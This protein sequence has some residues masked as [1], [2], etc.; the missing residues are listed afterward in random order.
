MAACGWPENRKRRAVC[1]GQGRQIPSD[2]REHSICAG[3]F[4]AVEQMFRNWPVDRCVRR[5][6]CWLAD[7]TSDR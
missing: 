5:F 2:L 4:T 7:N 6:F 3:V 1:P